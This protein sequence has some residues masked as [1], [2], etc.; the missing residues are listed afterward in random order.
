[1]DKLQYDTLLAAVLATRDSVRA[2]APSAV[3]ISERLAAAARR[4]QHGAHNLSAAAVDALRERGRIAPTSRPTSDEQLT[5]VYA[6]L[7]ELLN[8]LENG[9]LGATTVD[10]LDGVIIAGINRLDAMLAA[11]RAMHCPD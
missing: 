11:H 8:M 1:M 7:Q 5:L 2:L 6:G 4:E 3:E 9:R 10:A